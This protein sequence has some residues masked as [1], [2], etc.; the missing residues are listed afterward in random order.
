MCSA[1]RTVSALGVTLAVGAM[2][3]AQILSKTPA[4][5][6]PIPPLQAPIAGFEYPQHQ[7]L[8]FTVDWRVFTAGIA[9][10]HL[11]QAGDALKI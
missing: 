2:G 3:G 5:Q 10:F 11:D 1:L 4:P 8:T 6:R 7:V 9:V